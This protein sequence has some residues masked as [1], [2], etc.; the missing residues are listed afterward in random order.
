[1]EVCL[2][3]SVAASVVRSLDKI[4]RTLKWCMDKIASVSFPAFASPSV[5]CPMVDIASELAMEDCIPDWAIAVPDCKAAS[6][7]VVCLPV[8]CI[9]SACVSRAA[10]LEW[11]AARE[12]VVRAN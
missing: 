4:A 3:A 1:M 5:V 9:V 2:A 11:I 10:I 12:V 6:P 7:S 8:P